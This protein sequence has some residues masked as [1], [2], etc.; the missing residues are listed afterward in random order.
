MKLGLRH[1]VPNIFR[2]GVGNCRLL[3]VDEVLEQ[4]STVVVVVVLVL[5]LI[6]FYMTTK[7]DSLT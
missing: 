3:D 6:S 2:S 7:T 5:N 4:V 1:H